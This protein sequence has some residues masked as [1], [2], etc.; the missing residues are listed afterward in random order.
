MEEIT[1][2]LDKI[3]LKRKRVRW[4]EPQICKQKLK[5]PPT[6]KQKIQDR[7]DI[8]LK[9]KNNTNDNIKTIP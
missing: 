9:E 6:K 3:S 7:I 8:Y 2:K 5:E 4:C 1:S